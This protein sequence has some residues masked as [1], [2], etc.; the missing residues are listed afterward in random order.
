MEGRNH[1][2]VVNEN[3]DPGLRSEKSYRQRDLAFQVNYKSDGTILVAENV[4]ECSTC[5]QT[6]H[7]CMLAKMKWYIPYISVNKIPSD[8]PQQHVG[9]RNNK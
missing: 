7:I 3:I 8:T 4:D 5:W 1:R 9:T 6:R 2:G